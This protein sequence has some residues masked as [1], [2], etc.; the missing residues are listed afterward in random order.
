[1]SILRIFNDSFVIC[2]QEKIFIVQNNEVNH[3]I[4]ISCFFYEENNKEEKNS[5][6]KINEIKV[7]FYRFN[8]L[9]LKKNI[10]I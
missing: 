1:M 5:C 6:Q 4:D 3:I 7:F 10:Y 9:C 8:F 2:A